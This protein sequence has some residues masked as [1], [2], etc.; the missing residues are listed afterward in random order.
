MAMQNTKLDV[1]VIAATRAARHASVRRRRVLVLSL[2]TVTVVTLVVGY[3]AHFSLFYGL[4]PF[5]LF[6]VVI[7]LG[8]RASKKARE[9]EAKVAAAQNIKSGGLNQ[10]TRQQSRQQ[11]HHGQQVHEQKVQ[12]QKDQSGKVLDHKATK[13]D[14]DVDY[15]RRHAVQ[16][17]F[18]QMDDASSAP[19]YVIPVSKALETA[20]S[21][22]SDISRGSS[23]RDN[24]RHDNAQG[25]E[26][27]AAM[28]SGKT[29]VK[30]VSAMQPELISFS[31]G[32]PSKADRQT[33]ERAREEEVQSLEIRS[34]RQVAKA[35]PR[36]KAV[37]RAKA[38]SIPVPTPP[39]AMA[40]ETV[41]SV[42]VPALTEDS[43]GA[44]VDAILSRRRRM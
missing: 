38:P 6:A 28:K 32:N 4:I 34:Q 15:S 9:W 2:L 37:A 26:T 23:R 35:V 24:V 39:V 18:E 31:L 14:T 17:T 13:A 5:A 22:R 27:S 25:A 44:D 8:V 12:G 7:A 10:H 40:V 20:Q 29:P 30:E 42:D 1:D 41:V 16:T 21:G 33:F 3:F 36:A 43:L 11:S 19:T